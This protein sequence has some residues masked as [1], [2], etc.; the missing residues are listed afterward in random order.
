[1]QVR[2]YVCQ[3][4]RLAY[5]SSYILH[6]TAYTPSSLLPAAYPGLP[7]SNIFIWEYLLVM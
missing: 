5:S 7:L 2:I 4:Q 1:M 6:P 3:L